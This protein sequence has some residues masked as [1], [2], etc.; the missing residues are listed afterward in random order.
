[1]LIHI[2]IHIHILIFIQIEP[3]DPQDAEV[4][5]MYLANYEQFASTAR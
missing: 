3:S 4:A 1:M 2:H 5:N